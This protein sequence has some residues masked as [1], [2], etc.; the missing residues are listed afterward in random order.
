MKA[1]IEQGKVKIGSSPG[2]VHLLPTVGKRMPT[3]IGQIVSFAIAA[4]AAAAAAKAQL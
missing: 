2:E 4:A 3:S 1:R